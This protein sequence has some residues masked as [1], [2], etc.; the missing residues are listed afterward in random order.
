M[1]RS[2]T[3]LTIIASALVVV[4]TI[5][6]A[7]A[8]TA[9]RPATKAKRRTPTKVSSVQLK[10]SFDQFC[11]EWMQKLRERERYNL[12]H[13]EWT[14]TAD[15]VVGK[16]VGYSEEYTCILTDGK[17]PVGKM[18]YQQMVYEKKGGTAPTAEDSPPRA[19]EQIDTTEFFSQFKGK[20]YY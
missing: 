4:A 7:V 8:S 20:W 3:L 17:P 12:A 16:Y 10:Q 18:R 19:I 11:Q 2:A 13:I 14:P 1:M 6:S 9:A 15:G 5:G